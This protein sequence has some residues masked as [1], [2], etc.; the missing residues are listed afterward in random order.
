MN[1]KLLLQAMA[2]DLKRVAIGYHS[3]ST[4]MADIFL[5]EVL[6]LEQ[7][8]DIESLSPTIK[9]LVTYVEL[10]PNEKNVNKRAENA[11]LYSTLFLSFSK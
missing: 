7:Q 11:L 8:L 6:K 2:L 10:L 9:K 3:G 4:K 5:Q 1:N